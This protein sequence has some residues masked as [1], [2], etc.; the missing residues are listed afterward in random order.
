MSQI[1]NKIRAGFFATPERQ[2]EYIRGLLSFKEDTAVFD[3]T[4][5]EGNILKQLTEARE[6]RDFTIHTYGVELDKRRA[7]RAKESLDSVVQSPI[8]AMVISHEVFGMV[9][10]NPPYDNTMMGIGDDKTDR[11]EY[12]E[13][14]R[15]TKYLKPHGTMIFII[16]SYRFAD[17]KIARFLSTNFECSHIARFSDEDYDDF[18]QCVF[19]GIK[20]ESTYKEFN[21]DFNETLLK[22]TDEDY[23]KEHITQIN[24]LVTPVNIYQNKAT[25]FV[26][27]TKTNVPIF[28]SRIENKGDL[29]ESIKTN[30]GFEAFIARTR[31]KQLEIAGDPIINIAQGQNA[32]LLA[33][34]GVNGLI[35]E[36]DTLHAVQGM[37][38]VSNEVTVETIETEVITKRR[39]KREV[40]VKCI[41]PAGRVIKLV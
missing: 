31:P 34:G 10:L 25:Y 24:H 29:I 32:L 38:I 8:E 6:P 16:P 1:G 41:T 26:K 13:L 28:Y 9:F 33:S 14:V 2:G 27:A 15:S 4:C 22:M 11:K 5:G 18:R 20:K 3:P 40:S 19:I 37:E 30:K 21:P 23:V 12:M 7:Q 35:G 36:E 39:T 17:P